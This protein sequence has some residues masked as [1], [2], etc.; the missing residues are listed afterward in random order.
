M[1]AYKWIQNIKADVFTRN[2]EFDEAMAMAN[3]RVKWRRL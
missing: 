1:C 2:I 3:A